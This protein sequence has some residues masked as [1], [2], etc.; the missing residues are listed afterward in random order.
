MRAHSV[1]DFS[2]SYTAKQ[3]WRQASVWGLS[4]P[5]PVK[6]RLASYRETDWSIISR[7]V[8]RNFK[9]WD[10]SAVKI[11]KKK[12]LQ[13]VC[14]SFWRTLSAR[15]PP[16]ASSLGPTGG[17]PSPDPP[18]YS[19][20]NDEN[21]CRHHCCYTFCLLRSVLHATLCRFN[22]SPLSLSVHTTHL[23]RSS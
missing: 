6:C 8:V 7:W 2:Y 16:G 17:L 11:C 4:P 18:G 9:I 21:S 13:T 22:C 23:S 20:S 3:C 14:F 19:P 15:P 10:V 1:V 5:P 12:C